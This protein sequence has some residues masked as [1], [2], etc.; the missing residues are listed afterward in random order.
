MQSNN[1]IDNDGGD[2]DGKTIRQRASFLRSGKPHECICSQQNIF[3]CNKIVVRSGAKLFDYFIHNLLL[4]IQY[5]KHTAYVTYRVLAIHFSI[6]IIHSALARRQKKKNWE[7]RKKQTTTEKK[8]I[9]ICFKSS[10]NCIVVIAA[11]WVGS[12]FVMCV[13]GKALRNLFSS[14][15][16]IFI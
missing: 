15:I 12:M 13:V 10:Q 2:G 6:A 14:A 16:A 4:C 9:E 1:G 7:N 3:E 8:F 5:E 11:A